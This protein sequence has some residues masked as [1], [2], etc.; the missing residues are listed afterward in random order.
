MKGM[1]PSRWRAERPAGY[2][3]PIGQASRKDYRGQFKDL[4]RKNGMEVFSLTKAEALKTA[5]C[6]FRKEVKI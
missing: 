5:E 1:R 4:M 2:Y 3:C 6:L